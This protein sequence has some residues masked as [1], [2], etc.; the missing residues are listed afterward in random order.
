MEGARDT[1]EDEDY[2]VKDMVK[3]QDPKLSQINNLDKY[4]VIMTAQGGS[5]CSAEALERRTGQPPDKPSLNEIMAEIQTMR[6]IVELKLDAVMTEV[7]LLRADLGNMSDKVKTA[8]SQITGLQSTT[9]RLEDQKDL[10][11]LEEW[12]TRDGTARLIHQL[13]LKQQE[14]CSLVEHKARQ[15]AVAG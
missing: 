4:T 14:L 9:K 3:N 7:N 12:V 6:S 5:P 10:I 8:E 11:Q 13:Q 15:Y 2:H 1:K